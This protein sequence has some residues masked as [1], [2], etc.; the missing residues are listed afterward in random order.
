MTKDEIT[1]LA[2]RNAETE[3]PENLRASSD[4][5]DRK[6]ARVAAPPTG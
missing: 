2:M 3:S 5:V 6:K 4:I 1:R